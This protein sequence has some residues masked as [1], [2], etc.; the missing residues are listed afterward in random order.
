MQGARH[1]L[2]QPMLEIELTSGANIR[3]THE[4][5]MYA[6]NETG[7]LT[8]K[9]A[10]DVHCGEWLPLLSR[11]P[12]SVGDAQHQLNLLRHLFD[13]QPKI[14]E[15]VMV[16][17][18]HP[19]GK[20]TKANYVAW[21]RILAALAKKSPMFIKEI[22]LYAGYGSPKAVSRH[23]KNLKEM[24]FVREVPYVGRERKKLFKLT[25]DGEGLQKALIV[26][27]KKILYN[28]SSRSHYVW[29][30][31]VR[32]V[33]EVL[34][35]NIV[36]NWSVKL[37]KSRDRLPV[38]LMAI[39]ELA[40]LIGY[41]VAEGTADEFRNKTGGTSRRIA[42]SSRDLEIRNDL[43]RCFNRVFGF[44]LEV[45]AKHITSNSGLV[46]IIFIHVLKIGRYADEKNIPDFIMNGPAD[47]KWDF[48]QTYDLGDGNKTLPYTRW[49][50]VSSHLR[51][52]L[53]LLA[54][55][56]GIQGVFIRRDS[57]VRRILVH[58]SLPFRGRLYTGHRVHQSFIVPRRVAL[59]LVTKARSDYDSFR[60]S[61]SNIS[62]SRLK[63]ILND[64]ENN[65]LTIPEHIRN[66]LG[67]ELHFEQIVKTHKVEQHG[68]YVYDLTVEAPHTL[69]AGV[70]FIGVSN[71]YGYAGWVG[72]R[73]FAR[74]VAEATTAWGRYTIR[75]TIDLARE[76]GLELIYGDT[77]SVFVSY[78]PEKVERFLEAVE[79]ELGLEIRPDKVYE[80]ALFTKAKKRYAGLLP[81]GRLDIVGL[82]VAR[83]D[84][85]AVAKDVQEG[86]LEIVLRERS[87][88]KAADFVRR[89]IK[90]LRGGKIPYRDLIIW[91]TLTKP[92]GEYKVNTPHVA[93]ARR[94]MEA[95]WELTLGDKVGFVITKGSGR[96][97]ER[98]V[99]YPFAKYDDLD[100]RYYEEK[101]AIPAASRVL[102]IFKVTKDE[103]KPRTPI[104][105]YVG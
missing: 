15:N 50:T 79:R 74:P 27:S 104:E 99:P 42:W 25:L 22:A 41:Y 58:D 7:E 49:T 102:S 69:F 77:D 70:G 51:D 12:P 92:P 82:E 33:I 32:D 85:A 59:P 87:P 90:D 54:K 88:E 5:K 68:P 83:G 81:D 98:A 24:G 43:I 35:L 94:L 56:L 93:A 13:V 14:T 101:Q 38:I 4:H 103:L 105:D 30:N 80:R 28:P 97:Y 36:Q 45:G 61:D 16:V 86:A 39:C 40:R 8:V 62:K 48:L 66:F 26:L 64:S 2:N 67:G 29:F 52:Q 89:Y 19:Y 60:W 72:A 3:V 53:V 17:I 95:G 78:E 11:I 34:P 6:L 76:T 1:L 47:V 73:W 21:H 65:N 75:R 9:K 37:Y 55:Q 57:G 63:Q 96:L 10:A 31:D 46:Y 18:Q 20:R 100:L 91:K 71:C 23:L 84:W 44:H